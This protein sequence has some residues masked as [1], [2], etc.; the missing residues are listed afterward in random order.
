MNKSSL[1]QRS[2]YSKD[3]LEWYKKQG[4]E[5]KEFD[6]VVCDERFVAPE[7][8]NNLEKKYCSLEHQEIGEGEADEFKCQ[9]CG[10]K[11]K[12]YHESSFCSPLCE[13]KAQLDDKYDLNNIDWDKVRYTLNDLAQ[14][15]VSGTNIAL[16]ECEGCGEK[17]LYPSYAGTKTKYCS[18]E[19]GYLDSKRYGVYPYVVFFRDNFRCRYCGKRPVD[20]VK[21]TLDHVYPQSEGG[22][23]DLFNLVTSCQRCNSHK[24]ASLWDEKLI[25]DIWQENYELNKKIEPKP[26]KKMKNEFL[27]RIGE[28]PDP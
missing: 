1:V 11:I 22:G 5:I 24:E 15:K 12:S 17:F 18:N 9:W 13:A 3:E 27:E 10:D 20:G 2:R 28:K 21:L 25:K 14:A 6:C 8:T 23:D 26:Y 7:C 16:K 4:Y 19:C